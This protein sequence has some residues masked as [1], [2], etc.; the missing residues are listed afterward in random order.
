VLPVGTALRATVHDTD[1]PVGA[2]L[3]Q[4]LDPAR[5]GEAPSVPVK[6]GVPI[7]AGSGGRR[8]RPDGE[9]TQ[10][11]RPAEVRI[12][13]KKQAGTNSVSQAVRWGRHRQSKDAAAERSAVIARPS[14]VVRA[15]EPVPP[16]K[17]A[18]DVETAGSRDGAVGDDAE[19]AVEGLGLADLLAGALAAYRAI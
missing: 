13:P 14:P 3:L 7:P 9:S 12:P 11:E 6:W 16:P 8:R 18:N 4:R 2:Q 15:S 10:S 5:R 1:G 19:L 17:A